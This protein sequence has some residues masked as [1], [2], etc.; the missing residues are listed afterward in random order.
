MSV[1]S[2]FFGS[3]TVLPRPVYTNVTATDTHHCT[4]GA[5]QY[6]VQAAALQGHLGTDLQ[7]THAYQNAHQ[8]WNT[9]TC[10]LPSSQDASRK[11]GYTFMY[12]N[13]AVMT[14]RY[15]NCKRIFLNTFYEPNSTMILI[16]LTMT[17]WNSN[18][19]HTAKCTP[20]ILRHNF[21]SAYWETI[22]YENW[23]L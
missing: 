11:D 4:S 13:F 19:L 17:C 21:C 6:A 16:T 2:Y 18:V 1:I 20:W 14:T 7:Q 5:I 15:S 3:I 9:L 12:T 10:K 8:D 23:L 22:C